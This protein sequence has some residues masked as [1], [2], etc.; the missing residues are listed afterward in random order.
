MSVQCTLNIKYILSLILFPCTCIWILI[1]SDHCSLHQKSSCQCIRY[2]YTSHLLTWHMVNVCFT[3]Y[4]VRRMHLSL[5]TLHSLFE[6]RKII[7]FKTDLHCVPLYSVKPNCFTYY[8]WMNNDDIQYTNIYSQCLLNWTNY[9]LSHYFCCFGLDLQ[10]LLLLSVLNTLSTHAN[11]CLFKNLDWKFLCFF[12]LRII[13]RNSALFTIFHPTLGVLYMRLY[14]IPNIEFNI[15]HMQFL[16]SNINI[17]FS[18]KIRMMRWKTVGLSVSSVCQ[19]CVTHWSCRVDTCVCAVI[20]LNLCA[21][22]PLAARSV[23]RHSEPYSRSEPWG[24]NNPCPC[25]RSVY[26]P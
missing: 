6:C 7:W 3:S 11:Q 1:I 22:R 16:S 20:V 26:Y 21:I 4:G 10:M 13:H 19:T 23:A 5:V 14:C 9:Q 24:R 25:K 15:N 18:W 8:I 2:Y 17:N 12:W